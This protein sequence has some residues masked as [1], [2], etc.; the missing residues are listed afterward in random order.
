MQLTDFDYHLPG[1]L[2]AKEPLTRRDLSRL[3]IVN[4]EQ[5][6]EKQFSDI[7]E[8]IDQDDL[9]VFNNSKVLKARLFGQKPSGGKIEILIER[10]L[11]EQNIIAHVRSN[12][13]V[14]VGLEILLPDTQKIRVTK[15]LDGLF[16]LSFESP[17]NIIKYLE[18]FGHIPL[19]PYI[20]R[21]DT[22]EDINRYQTVYAKPYGSVAAPTAGLHFSHSLLNKIEQM[23]IKT[24]FITLHVGSGT[25]KPVSVNDISQHKMHSEYYSVNKKTI[26]LINHAQAKGG[27]IIAVGTTSLRTLETIANNGMIA[28]DGETDIFITPGYKFKLV[29]KLITNFHLPKST[30]LMLVSAFA[31]IDNIKKAYRFAIENKYRFY[32]YGDAMLLNRAD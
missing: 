17:L 28:G 24:A 5:L 22:P 19:P 3:L 15:I 23:G 20:N 21:V 1:D 26:E 13:T 6:I 27:K 11:D 31:G 16:R 2:I 14:S 12:K 10:I 32:S 4:H 8:Y 18:Q 30:L 9:L 25:F 7:I 29:E